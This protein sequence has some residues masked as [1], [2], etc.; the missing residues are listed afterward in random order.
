[1]KWKFRG[2]ERVKVDG[3]HV[4]ISWDLHSFLFE[5][6]NADAHAIFM[7]KFEED[8]EE[9]TGEHRNLVGLWNLGVCEVGKSWSSSSVSSSA[10]S[11]GGSSSV[12]EWSSVEENELVVPIGFS[13]LVYASKR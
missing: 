2:N 1:M 13:L 10:C 12:L 8:E 7:F 5:K 4:Q 6:N 11:F 3:V 9:A